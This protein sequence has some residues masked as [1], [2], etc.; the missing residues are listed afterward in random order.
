MKLHRFFIE[1]LK[2]S[3][4]ETTITDEKTIHQLRRVLRSKVGDRI[5]ITDSGNDF[6]IEIEELGT[7]LRG[8]VLETKENNNEP[9]IKISL[10][11]SFCKKDKFEWILQKGTE[12]GISE[13]IPVIAERSEKLGLNTER[14]NKI[15]KEAAEQSERGIVPSLLKEQMLDDALNNVKGE[16]LFLDRSGESIKDYNVSKK[17]I[18]L[19]IGPEGG[20]TQE[21]LKLAKESG[22]KIISTGKLV[23]RTETTGPVAAAII[24]N[25]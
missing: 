4:D 22:A 8:R 11:Q 20:W 3:N 23:L 21:E 19:F 25:K 24:L 18:S 5:I 14:A 12:I 10:Y 17:E 9:D 15:L 1:K 7:I 13:F 6:L 2:I 16:K